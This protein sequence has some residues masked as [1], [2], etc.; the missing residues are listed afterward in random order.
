MIK[1]ANLLKGAMETI[2]LQTVSDGTTYGY[3]IAK[4]IREVTHG[5]VL[6]QEGTLYPALHR[7]EA[8]GYLQ[9][10]WRTS[11]QGRER[12]HY[13][14]TSLGR[15]RLESLRQEWNE[16]NE[17]MSTILKFSRYGF[18]LAASRRAELPC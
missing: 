18:P 2:V 10:T 4:R 13:Q 14:I 12:K 6:S 17:A 9:S 15:K 11:P 1:N 16:F 5:R 8:R 3:A 7:L